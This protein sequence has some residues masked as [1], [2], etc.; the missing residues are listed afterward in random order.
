MAEDTGSAG[1]AG[2]L[3]QF[4]LVTTGHVRSCGTAGLA[5]VKGSHLWCCFCVY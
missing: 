2:R 3:G 1:W 4:I 5:A